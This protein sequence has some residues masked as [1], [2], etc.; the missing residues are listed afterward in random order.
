MN[1]NTPADSIKSPFYYY[2]DG[3]NLAVCFCVDK[4]FALKQI[5]IS[6][7]QHF[8]S[9]Y[10]ERDDALW[11]LGLIEFSSIEQVMLFV[12][13]WD[14]RAQTRLGLTSPSAL[15]IWS[16]S[17]VE[18]HRLITFQQIRDEKEKMSKGNE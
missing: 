18:P 9:D 6:R 14:A 4:D 5:E 16:D 12:E 1:S 17:P 3:K 7:A 8:T 11:G 2:F 15:A 13:K 10:I